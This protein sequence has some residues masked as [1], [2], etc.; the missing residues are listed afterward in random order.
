[1]LVLPLHN[2]AWLAL[3]QVLASE[4][5]PPPAATGIVT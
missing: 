1:M 4:Q 3:S 2:S 5:L